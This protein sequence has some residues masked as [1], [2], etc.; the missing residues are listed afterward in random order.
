LQLFHIASKLLEQLNYYSMK[1][2]SIN[3]ITHINT[4]EMLILFL[5]LKKFQKNTQ[6]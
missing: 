6:T 5:D 1:G 3:K 2:I 4:S